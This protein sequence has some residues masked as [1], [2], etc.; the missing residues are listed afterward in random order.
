[1]KIRR[2]L[3]TA[4]AAAV[5]TPVV[6]LSAGTAVA[7]TPKPSQEQ[8]AGTAD[9][10]DDEAPTIAELEAAVEAAQ[11]KV[12]DLKK[13][14]AQLLVDI[15]AKKVP[16][17]VQAEY[18]GAK[19][20][21][22]DARVATAAAVQ[23]LTAAEAELT[24][25][26][27]DP[28]ATEQQKTDAKQAVADAV[29]ARDAAEAAERTAKERYD[30]ANT[31]WFDAHVALTREHTR[32]GEE[33]K[34]AEE[35]LA[36]AKDDLEFWKS[37]Q[38]GCKEDASLSFSLTGPE[39]IEAGGSGIFTLALSN[40]SD[41]D[42]DDVLAYPGAALFDGLDEDGKPLDREDLHDPLDRPTIEWSSKDVLEW[43]EITDEFD[44]AEFGAIDK[45][46]TSEVKL[47]VTVDGDVPVNVGTLNS[48]AM[49]WGEDGS[50]GISDEVAVAW[51]DVT[52]AG[53]GEPT[54]TQE[55]TTEPTPEPSPSTS[56]PAPAATSNT[57]QQGGSSNTPVTTGGQLA[58]TGANDTLPQLGAA[59]G[60]AVVLGA[61]AL[62]VARRRKAD[63]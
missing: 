53:D 46:H 48:S 61:G 29:E 25:V 3:A 56:T 45:G 11:A 50:C 33:L 51:F 20:A 17:D 55:P 42:L 6:F 15:E 2:I 8:S 4:V 21:Y 59:A 34:T 60:A 22:D 39:K 14:R 38:E 30:A 63:A 10:E 31:A 44:T 32:L 1:M 57:T 5:T 16:A 18:D 7:E 36:T 24:K 12:D 47:R 43:T 37:I 58:A 28:N 35:E 62:F 54:P 49:Y 40:V 9:H 26:N 27:E 23:A 41:R 13:R 52:G 19:Q